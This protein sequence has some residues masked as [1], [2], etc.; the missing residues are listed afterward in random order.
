MDGDYTVRGK[1]AYEKLTR[2][3][4]HPAS[5]LGVHGGDITS[6]L[7]DAMQALAYARNR[8]I[9]RRTGMADIGP[10]LLASYA[11]GEPWGW[12]S[13]VKAYRSWRKGGQLLPAELA[14]KLTLVRVCGV[15][16][17]EPRVC[18]IATM[19]G[20]SRT[21]LDR[22]I[23]MATGWAMR[24]IDRSAERFRAKLGDLAVVHQFEI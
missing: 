1:V 16:I 11:I 18:R 5:L 17:S 6:G 24:C 8:N 7:N 9:I 3:L 10:E 2:I 19:A 14:I 15:D 4:P 23:D 22:E 12:D 20:M 21:A 13:I